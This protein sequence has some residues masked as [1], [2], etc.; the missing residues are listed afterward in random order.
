MDWCYGQVID[1]LYV[2]FWSGKVAEWVPFIGNGYLSLFPIFNIADVAIFLGVIAI[3]WVRKQH[4]PHQL[5]PE[6]TE[7][8]LE[9]T[10]VLT[11]KAPVE[12]SSAPEPTH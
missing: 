12:N 11:P 4:L 7:E 2:D 5:S 3:L 9:P 6:I 10:V 1:M 8:S